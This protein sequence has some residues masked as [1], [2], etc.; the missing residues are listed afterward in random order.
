M[1]K[2][3]LM[4]MPVLFLYAPTA[5]FSSD[6]GWGYYYWL[7]GPIG[8]HQS[9][10]MAAAG[11]SG[12]EYRGYNQFSLT[13]YPG[14]GTQINSL[15]LRLRNN[16]G[17]AGLQ[18][19]INRV[20]SSTPD[21]D[22]CGGTAPVYLTYQPV[23]ANSEEYT[24]FDLTGTQ[25]LAD[26]LDA[27]QSGASW[28]GLGYKGSRGSGEP[29]MHFFYAWWVDPVLDA[30]LIADYTIVGIEEIS[31]NDFVCPKMSI[32]PNPFRERT[33]ISFST[34]QRAKSTE[35]S[36]YNAAGKQVKTISLPTAYSVLP[37]VFS[38]DGT[39]MAGNSV[40]SGVYFVKCHSGGTA[41]SATVT[42]LR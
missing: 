3:V 10:G 2:I 19:D 12:L 4:L 33:E 39:D 6:W 38:W 11:Y 5:T 22:E 36:I 34:G 18:I 7:F 8:P 1:K 17:G 25:A 24:F 31:D 15:L 28:F 27:W 35:L 40:P 20:Q 42:L 23:S 32:Q 21:W 9:D 14:T 30:T 41:V 13:G 26:F 37:T 29:C 16:T